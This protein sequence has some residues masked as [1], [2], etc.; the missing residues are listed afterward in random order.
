MLNVTLPG[1]SVNAKAMRCLEIV[2]T[3]A[4]R[5]GWY[6]SQRYAQVLTVDGS[7]AALTLQNC[8][9][10]NSSRIWRQIWGVFLAM[11]CEAA[12]TRIVRR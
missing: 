3:S 12:D 1:T 8:P 10:G 2:S 5:V 11:L 9:D 7:F 4:K 6:S